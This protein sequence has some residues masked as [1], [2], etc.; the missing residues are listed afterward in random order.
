MRFNVE[1]VNIKTGERYWRTIGA[2]DQFEAM[3]ISERY[4]R[5]GFSRLSMI[6]AENKGD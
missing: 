3:M 2:N 5:K 4:A 1:Y 6:Q